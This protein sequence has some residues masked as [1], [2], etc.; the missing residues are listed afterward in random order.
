MRKCLKRFGIGFGYFATALAVAM[1]PAIRAQYASSVI[2]YNPGT[3]A[4]AGF[5]D[6]TTALGAPSTFTNDPQFP[7]PVDPYDPPY[8]TSQIVSMGAGGSLTLQLGAPVRNDAS[9]AFGIDF[10]VYGNAGFNE[11][12]NTG[13]T[14][15]TL[16]GSDATSTRVSVSADNVTYF[17]LDPNLAPIFDSYFPTDG[18]GTIGKPVNPSLGNAVSFNAMTLDQIRAQYGGS[19]GGTGYDLAWARDGSGNPVAIDSINYV[20]LEVLGGK[21]EIDGV[22]AVPEPSTWALLGVGAFAVFARKRR[23]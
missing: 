5:N 20:K 1:T 6:P 14:D 10:I 18:S 9:H 4:A 3:G 17:T 19:A 23:A 16:F 2:S 15:G 8:L 12:F 13:K 7:G 21:A 22:A 11:D